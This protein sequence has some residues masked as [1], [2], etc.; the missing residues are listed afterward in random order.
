MLVHDFVGMSETPEGL[1]KQTV[2][3]LEYTRR[4]RVVAHAKKRG[5]CATNIRKTRPWK[6]GE[7]ELSI[8]DQYTYLGVEIERSALGM[9]IEQTQYLIERAYKAHVGKMN[10]ILTDS[11]LDARIKRGILMNVYQ[12]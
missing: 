2:E 11:H 5:S 8:V 10:A 4:C 6:W 9:H 1:Q 7:D 3:A 12:S